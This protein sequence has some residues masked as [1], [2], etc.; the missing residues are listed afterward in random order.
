MGGGH[1]T[2]TVKNER[3]QEWLHYDDSSVRSC[4]ECDVV[5]R[6]AYIL[7]YRR[8]DLAGKPMTSVV[9]RLNR[10]FF[11]GMPVRTRSGHDCYLIEYRE[12]HPCPLVLGLGAGITIYTKLDEILPDPDTEDLSSFNNMFKAAKK[13]KNSDADG[14]RNKDDSKPIA[15]QASTKES[16]K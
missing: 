3:T 14:S 7:F 5:A 6:S 9:P 1:Y 12:N 13:N 8:K 15:A 16:R 10:N 2:A 11:P 4:A